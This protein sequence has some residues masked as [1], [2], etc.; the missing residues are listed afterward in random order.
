[1]FDAAVLHRGSHP[2]S[3]QTKILAVL[4]FRLEDNGWPCLLIFFSDALRATAF[5][6]LD[7]P[8]IADWLRQIPQ[9]DTQKI[10][11][12]HFSLH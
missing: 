12:W 7:L 1:M 8:Q 11:F 4:F 9:A 6:L 5:W 2:A 3:W 10:E